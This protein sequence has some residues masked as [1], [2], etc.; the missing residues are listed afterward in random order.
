MKSALLCILA[1]CISIPLNA[2]QLT[3]EDFLEEPSTFDMEYSPSGRH[4]ATVR[5]SEKN[6]IVTIYEFENGGSR[7]IIGQFGDAIIRPYAVQWANDDRLLVHLLV[8]FNTKKVIKDSKKKEDFNIREHTMFSRSISVD[9]FGKNPVLLM[10]KLAKRFGNRSLSRIKHML[11]DDPNHVLMKAYRGGKL[12]LFKVNINTG[13]TTLVAK[14]GYRTTAFIV[15]EDGTVRFRTD[16][17]RVANVIQILELKD[18]K[19]EKFERIKFDKD[20]DKAVDPEGLAGLYTDGTLIY[21]KQNEETG[22]YELV[23]SNRETGHSE[24]LISL[25]NQNIVDLLYDKSNDVIGYRVE[26]DVLKNQYFSEEIQ[27]TYDQIFEKLGQQAFHF[28]SKDQAGTVF[29]VQSY[30]LSTPGEFFGYTHESGKLEFFFDRH[31]KLNR[32]NLAI[33]AI[34]TYLARDGQSIRNYVLLPPNFSEGIKYPLVVIPHGGPAAR[35]YAYFDR[36]AQFIAT[37]GYIVI[38]PN[39]R[40]S[41]GYGKAF[42]E[43]GY[44]QWG[45]LMQD[46]VD[47]AVDFMIRKGYADKSQVC[48]AGISYGGYSA[49]M[50]ASL[51]PDLYKCA[52]SINGVT[53]L[54]SMVKYDV[55]K[56]KKE[57]DIIEE[58]YKTIGH[59][60]EDQELLEKASPINLIKTSNSPVLLIAGTEDKVVPYKQAKRY[61]KALSSQNISHKFI[62]VEDSGHNV[63]YYR[64]DIE[65]V[66]SEVEAFLAEHFNANLVD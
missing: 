59:P 42:E 62:T 15:S 27:K 4:L 65:L 36:F 61:S 66:F 17:Y 1:L 52:I 49:L 54:E 56:F 39:F 57:R 34:S 37:R 28:H 58:I 23:K 46:D 12:S 31:E 2:K 33:S 43:A 8:P 25:D 7:K 51:R 35:D 21:R 24:V 6:R 5:R 53:D 9:R 11:P 45:G 3:V 63:L 48:I 30:G 22:Y 47:D 10:E 13:E 40:G 38:Q 60:K 29:I 14:G 20:D 18:G 64:E 16:R 44:K 32:E 19:W 41:T 50:G 55:K 26:E